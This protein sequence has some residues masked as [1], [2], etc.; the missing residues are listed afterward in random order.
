[1]GFRR[2]QQINQAN[3]NA[4]KKNQKKNQNTILQLDTFT[5]LRANPQYA[6]EP[7]NH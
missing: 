4:K 7:V 2:E 5:D 6:E 1:M 3:S